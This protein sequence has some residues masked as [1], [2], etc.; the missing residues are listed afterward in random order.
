MKLYNISS[1]YFQRF[2]FHLNNRKESYSPAKVV[3]LKYVKYSWV[4]DIVVS[5]SSRVDFNLAYNDFP[6]LLNLITFVSTLHPTRCMADQRDMV[7]NNLFIRVLV[8]QVWVS[9]T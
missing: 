5:I 1:S 3:V 2:R 9:V 4:I 6:Y 7:V 8:S